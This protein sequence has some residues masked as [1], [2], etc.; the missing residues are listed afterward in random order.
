MY[1]DIHETLWAEIRTCVQGRSQT[2]IIYSD[3]RALKPHRSGGLQKSIHIYI[4]DVCYRGD[5]P[6]CPILATAM[7]SW[8]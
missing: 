7:I 5:H 2:M 4:I 3:N 8:L 6:G 1:L